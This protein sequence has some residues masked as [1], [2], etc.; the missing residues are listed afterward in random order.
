MRSVN[1]MFDIDFKYFNYPKCNQYDIK[2]NLQANQ[3]SNFDFKVQTSEILKDVKL[4]LIIGLITEGRCD[5]WGK[6]KRDIASG[7]NGKYQ[8]LQGL[9][10]MFLGDFME[11]M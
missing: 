4:L 8:N 3:M 10:K 11:M 2:K 6:R 1:W 5:I 7:L 9:I